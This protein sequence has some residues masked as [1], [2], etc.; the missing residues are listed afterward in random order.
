ME[1]T[2]KEKVK[3]ERKRRQRR[4]ALAQEF[5]AL[6]APL[7]PAGVQDPCAARAD[8]PER[9]RGSSRIF[10]LPAR[11]EEEEEEE[12][13]DEEGP[14]PQ[15]LFMT[16]FTILSSHF[17]CS[18]SGCCL[19]SPGLLDFWEM[20]SPMFPYSTLSLVPGSRLFDAVCT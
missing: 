3:E 8:G 15:L 5:L 6:R 18:V 4:E 16:S 1:K 20:T 7:G 17:L 2:A 12:E 9:R 11:E 13:K 14:F 10:F 19:T